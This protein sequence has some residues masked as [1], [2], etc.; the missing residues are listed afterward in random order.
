MHPNEDFDVEGPI[1]GT[2]LIR[3]RSKRLLLFITYLILA[4]YYLK[5]R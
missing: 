1:K 4:T 3:Y 2:T 5:V